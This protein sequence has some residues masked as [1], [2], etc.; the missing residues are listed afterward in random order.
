M[1]ESADFSLKSG[2][3]FPV[4]SAGNEYAM[5]SLSSNKDSQKNAS[6]IRES[7]PIGHLFASYLHEAVR[8]VFSNESFSTSNVNL[9]KREKE[10]LLWSADGKTSWE[11]SKI[12]GISERTVVFHLQN[13]A[14]KLNATNR[15]QA[16]ARSI[17]YGLIKP[18]V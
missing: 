8:R 4:H 12:L 13:A 17:I 2:I 15:Q 14:Q 5:F 9:S 7:L 10:C 1:H 18:Q 16:V 3:C 6:R 11:T